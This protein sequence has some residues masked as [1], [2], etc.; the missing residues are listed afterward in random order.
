MSCSF[1]VFDI[2]WPRDSAEPT[3]LPV[4]AVVVL[5]AS[6]VEGDSADD[7]E[8]DDH[9]NDA[10]EELFGTRAEDFSFEPADEEDDD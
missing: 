7:E 8:W 6:L 10:L 3:Q 9:V 4:E 1:R 5:P 2:D